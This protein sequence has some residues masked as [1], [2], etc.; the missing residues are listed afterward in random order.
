MNQLQALIAEAAESPPELGG[1]RAL[2]ESLVWIRLP[3]PGPLHHIN[4]WLLATDSGWLLV[5]TGLAIPAVEEA[6][7]R[8]GEDLVP[9][10]A[11]E[12]IVVT[13]HH[14][15]HFGM[16]ARLSAERG[17]EVLMSETAAAAARPDTA[18]PEAFAPRLSDFAGRLG[19][20]LEPGFG[21]FLSG[22]RYRSIVSGM[23][24]AQVP[25][26]EGQELPTRV[27][28][29]RVSLHHGHAPGHACLHAPEARLLVS[30]DQVLPTISPNIS[31]YP[32]IEDEDPL[33]RYLESLD[34]LAALPDDTMV[35]PAHGRPFSGL[36]ARLRALRE[37][38]EQRL[39][40]I[41]ETCRDGASSAEVIGSLFRLARL[42]PLNRLLATTETLAHLRYLERRGQVSAAGR[43]PALRWVSG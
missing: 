24:P 14:P 3:V 10:A 17:I 38:H 33:G 4:V 31:L 30:G 22:R 1:F 9:L 42:D 26:L 43:G 27:G 16:A 40:R 36:R 25:L 7:R 8:L 12:R 6:W 20:E 13:H 11:L 35:L 37:E 34:R 19:L 5:D 21:E 39:R 28:S 41:V 29:L 18:G 15:D 32:G 23:P 2:G